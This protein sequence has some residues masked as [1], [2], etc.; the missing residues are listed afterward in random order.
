MTQGRKSRTVLVIG[1]A[2]TML[3]AISA[4]APAFAGAQAAVDEYE[5]GDLPN[6]DGDNAGQSQNN[7]GSGD[8]EAAGVVPSSGSSTPSPP[9]AEGAGVTSAASGDASNQGVKDSGGQSSGGQPGK[10]DNFAGTP[11]ETEPVAAVNAES[12]D[13]GSAPVLLILLAI[14]A[15]IST[16]VAIWRLRRNQREPTPGVG[17]GTGKTA[18]TQS[19]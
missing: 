17:P 1:C 4:I 13:G 14:I 19:L 7:E 15:A 6:A 11:T 10:G 9:A 8:D 5:L 3:A 2:L 16:G 18:E 12:S